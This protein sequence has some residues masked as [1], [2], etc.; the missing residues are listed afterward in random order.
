MLVIFMP[1]S[2][3]LGMMRTTVSMS[4]SVTWRM[5]MSLTMPAVPSSSSM[6]LPMS[7]GLVALSIRPQIRSAMTGCA[8]KPAMAAM[9]VVPW[10]STR[11]KFWVSGELMTTN[12]IARKITMKRAMLSTKRRLML[13]RIPFSRFAAFFSSRSAKKATTNVTTVVK[14]SIM[15]CQ[16]VWWALKKSA[17]A[18]IC[19][20]PHL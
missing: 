1:F 15:D 14:T 13:S 18:V 16:R 12:C 11:P 10:N 4:C 8:A 5:V 17:I 2:L 3:L 19:L 7:K 6:R 20:S 9:T